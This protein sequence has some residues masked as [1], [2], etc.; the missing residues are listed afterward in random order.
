MERKDSILYRA[1]KENED[2]ISELLC[3]LMREKYVRDIF[4]IHLGIPQEIVKDIKFDDISSQV[5]LK[6]N[7]KP[8]IC[9]ENKD[10]LIYI[11][12]KIGR[13]TQLQANQIYSYPN[14]LKSSNKKH[15]Q[16]IYLIPKGYKHLA[17]I[18]T[19]CKGNG[20]CKKIFWDDFLIN[21]SKHEIAESN[22]VF[23]DCFRFLENKLLSKSISIKFKPEEIVIMYN[24]KD[25][26]TANNFFIK[27]KQVIDKADKIIVE[28]LNKES[29]DFSHGNWC[30]D[31][32][33]ENEKGKCLNYKGKQEIFYGLNLNL[34]PK[35]QEFLL[36]VAIISKNI[37][38]KRMEDLQ[39]EKEIFQDNECEWTYI[40]MD[41]YNLTDDESGE[42]FAKNVVEIIKSL[43]L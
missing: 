17:E 42:A 22:L 18:D 7:G 38:C 26:K 41:K 43:L 28:E 39:K 5:D 32:G 34:V 10:A 40:K 1:T 35:H 8:D 21:V 12:N 14:T 20:F 3:N 31:E 19:V 11:E 30:F 23:R 33:N 4:L 37:D 16:M 24:A 25:L 36:S 15:Y 2:S 6:E 29:K 27:L 9:L 13:D